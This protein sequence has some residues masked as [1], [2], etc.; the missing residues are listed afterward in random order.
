MCMIGICF[1]EA[2][3]AAEESKEREHVCCA[4][5][6]S[7]SVVWQVYRQHHVIACWCALKYICLLSQQCLDV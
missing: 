6:Q 7:Y 4:R 3:Y 2:L 1:K 5:K